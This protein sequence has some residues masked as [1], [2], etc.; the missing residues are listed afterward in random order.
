MPHLGFDVRDYS[1]RTKVG[2]PPVDDLLVLV[3][4]RDST[5][6]PLVEV[7]TSSVRLRERR[8]FFNTRRSASGLVVVPDVPAGTYA[9]RVEARYYVPFRTTLTSPQTAPLG[10]TLHRDASYPF[11]AEDTVIRGLVQKA[12]GAPNLG[13]DV[14]LTDTADPL[15]NHR[16]PLNAGGEYVA[17]FPEKQTTTG[18]SIRAFHSTGSVTVALASVVL[19]R[20]NLVPLITVP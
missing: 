13:F 3:P 15:I 2:A 11:G 14:L 9:A 1:T 5:L 7:S 16:V 12:S 18:M 20:S 4:R 19:N 6:A 8:L 10:V 17:F